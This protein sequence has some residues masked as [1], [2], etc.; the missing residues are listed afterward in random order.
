MISTSLAELSSS[1]EAKITVGGVRYWTG[2]EGAH[3]SLEDGFGVEA[4]AGWE[5]AQGSLD[6]WVGDGGGL[7]I[8]IINNLQQKNY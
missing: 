7:I 4:D 3:G 2:Q 1:D 6:E 8:V 5:G